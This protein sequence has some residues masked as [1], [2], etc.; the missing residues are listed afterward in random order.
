MLFEKIPSTDLMGV[1]LARKEMA[2]QNYKP[3]PLIETPCIKR[4]FIDEPIQQLTT[5]DIF[6][7]CYTK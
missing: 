7:K 3:R 5:E 2:K 1:W 4:P 6:N